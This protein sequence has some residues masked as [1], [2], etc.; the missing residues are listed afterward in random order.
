MKIC[1]ETKIHF[2]KRE[3]ERVF[4]LKEQK[5]KYKNKFI[6]KIILK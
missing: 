2:V 5:Q 4:W 3:R 6:F 1:T